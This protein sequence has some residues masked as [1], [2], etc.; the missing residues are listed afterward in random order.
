M[1]VRALGRVTYGLGGEA[2]IP[3]F[4]TEFSSNNM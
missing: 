1:P 3:I 4:K 2:R